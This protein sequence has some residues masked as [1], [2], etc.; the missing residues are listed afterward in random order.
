L[1][2]INACPATYE[3]HDL[4]LVAFSEC[5]D[6][7][8]VARKDLQVQFH[9]YTIG[10]HSQVGDQLGHRQAGGN[11]TRFA[12]DVQSHKKSSRQLLAISLGL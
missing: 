5:R 12:I 2:N 4:Q 8:L 11:V 1:F 10:F 3:V 7:P 9:G 6:L